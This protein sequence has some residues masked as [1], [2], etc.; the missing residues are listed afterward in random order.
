MT[1]S[2]TVLDQRTIVAAREAFLRDGTES[3]EL[4]EATLVAWRRSRAAGVDANAAPV[5]FDPGPVPDSALLRAVT[6]VGTTLMR[7]LDGTEAA[8]MVTDRQARIVGRW[9]ADS[10]MQRRLDSMAVLPGA[11][12]EE[13]KVGSTGLGSVLEDGQVTVIE[14]AEHYNSAFDP[15]TA[16][17]APIVH[18]GTGQ[19]EGVVD[20]VSLTGS[21]T[22]M[23]G[24]IVERA[25]KEMGERL[26]SGYAAED[27]ALLD[28]FLRTDRRGVRRPVLAVNHRMLMSNRMASAL[29]GLQTHEVLW[30]RAQQALADGCEI[31]DLGIP[32]MTERRAQ[33]RPV[34]DG[35]LLVGCILHLGSQRPSGRAAARRRSVKPASDLTARVLDKL[36]GTSLLWQSAVTDIVRAVTHR[37]RVLLTGAAGVGKSVLAATVAQLDSATGEI[38]SEPAV[39]FVRA[40]EIWAGM[41]VILVEQME[42]LGPADAHHFSQRIV[43]DGAKAPVIGILRT[44]GTT[45]V[46]PS[47]AAAFDRVVNLA[48]L[49]H[50]PEDIGPVASSLVDRMRPGVRISPEALSTIARRPWT[51]NVTQLRHA[52]Q[53]AL[54]RTEGT[55]L[56]PEHL[57]PPTDARPAPRSLTYLE[58]IERDAILALLVAAQGNKKQVA[59]TLGVSRATLYRKLASLG[60]D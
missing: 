59:L 20:L 35:G 54:D 30:E 23:M 48:P 49:D 58:R 17:G 4:R 34:H 55:L 36:P 44:D 28:A 22:K 24:A 60:I 41:D 47:L 8:M 21:P 45:P 15:V 52:L 19:I 42:E 37:E 38:R 29:P 12:F 53:I 13:A 39:K 7:Q 6:P 10:G 32:A 50:R 2:A 3:P 57:P 11:V 18:P 31:L 46:A 5:A 56:R 25:A 40:H 27:R 33:L 1:R 26:I 51:G 43:R 16:V 14:G 9:I